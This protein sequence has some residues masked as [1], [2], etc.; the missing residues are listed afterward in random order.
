MY[1][2]DWVAFWHSDLQKLWFKQYIQMDLDNDVIFVSC[3]WFQSVI[4]RYR[5]SQLKG[6]SDDSQA[7]VRLQ[8]LNTTTGQ[9]ELQVK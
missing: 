3:I 9:V 5:F 8:F 6:S 1:L 7:K 4:W 2:E